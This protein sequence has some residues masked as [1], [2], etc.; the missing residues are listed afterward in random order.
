MADEP[1]C[2][3]LSGSTWLAEQAERAAVVARARL[4]VVPDLPAARRVWARASLVL[5]GTDRAA[6]L[7]AAPMRR[8]GV[9]LVTQ[10]GDAEDYRLALAMGAERI[11]VLP[12][13]SGWLAQRIADATEGVRACPVVGVVGARGG[14]GA[15]T[16]VAALGLS[17]ARLGLES[18]LV[19][20]DPLGAGLDLLLDSAD[21]PG[22]RWHDLG[23]SEGRLPSGS[24][25]AALPRIGGT[26][27]LSAALDHPVSPP[28]AA[29]DSVLPA[30]ARGHD[31][32]VVDLPRWR[33]EAAA[34]AAA[35]CGPVLLVVPA[36]AASVRSAA[37]VAAMVS[38][39]A[40][41]LRLVVRAGPAGDPEDVGDHLGL[42]VAA[43][44]R[45]DVRLARAVRQ[46]GGL[47]GRGWL[48]RACRGL[49]RALAPSRAV[50]A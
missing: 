6:D 42:P 3:L 29:L 48:D 5:V 10:A 35:R 36:E 27:V 25:A 8:D 21:E 39:Q 11:A 4:V 23:S 40:A 50:A 38:A 28:P 44:L 43:V 41:D 17:A 7:G 18:V 37:Q 2:V 46:G 19:D 1:D 26:A 47:P 24:L 45:H 15:T 22:L 14:A 31:L 30:L 34:A 12:N 32:V 33:D 16:L 9:V 13:A 20:A 49:L